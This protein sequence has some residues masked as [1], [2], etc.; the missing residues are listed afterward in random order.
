MRTL[1]TFSLNTFCAATLLLLALSIPT[2]AADMEC[3]IFNPPPPP[4]PITAQNEGTTAPDANQ[5][6]IDDQDEGLFDSLFD[7]FTAL[8]P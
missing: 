3:G 7:W 8:L 6:G 1:R 5:N 2:Y 4:P